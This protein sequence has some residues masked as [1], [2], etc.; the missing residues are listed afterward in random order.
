MSRAFTMV[1]PALWRSARF[2]SLDNDGRLLFLYW[3]TNEHSNSA[4]C[5]RLPAA[6]GVADLGWTREQYDSAAVSVVD[7]G[8]AE[9][10]FDTDEVLIGKWFLHSPPTN[11]KHA[12]GTRS[13]IEKIESLDFQEKAFA[14][15]GET[16]FGL[17]VLEGVSNVHDITEHSRIASTPIG[18]NGGY[19]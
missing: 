11:V 19:R 16:K 17:Q 3:L 9:F 13:A 1:S 4:G 18:R 2:Q 10:D 12:M 6:Y 7:A 8:M 5:Y 14:A 15:F